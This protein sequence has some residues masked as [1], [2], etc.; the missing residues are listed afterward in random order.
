MKTKPAQFRPVKFKKI[1]NCFKVAFLRLSPLHQ[2]RNPIMFVVYVGAIFT[3]IDFLVNLGQDHMVFYASIPLVIWLT[4]YCANFAEAYAEERGKAQA[5]S[6]KR[7]R[8]DIQAKKILA[9]NAPNHF[10]IIPANHLVTGDLVVVEEGDFIP[11]DGQVVQGIATVDES[12]ITGE[13]AP[14]IRESGGDRDAVTGGTRLLSDTLI[15]RITA[16]PGES[17]LD[18]MIEMVEGASRQKTPNEVALGLL[19]SA[20]NLLF[21]VACATLYPYSSFAVE[22]EGYGEPLNLSILVALFVCIATTTISGLLSAIG[23]AGMNRLMNANVIASSGRAVEAAGDVNI[24]LLDKTGTITLGN[25]KAVAFIPAKAVSLRQLISAALLASLADNTPEGRSITD[26]A[27]TRHGFSKPEMPENSTFVPFSADTRVSGL[28]LPDRAYLK[29]AGDAINE[30]IK[31]EGGFIPEDLVEEMES[32]SIQ[33]GTPL[34]VAQDSQVLGLIHLKDVVKSGI[35]A[36]LAALRRM[37]IRSIMITGDNPLTA[38]AIAAEAGVD[39]FI[40]QATPETKL[41]YIRKMQDQG[42]LIAMV[43]DG[44]N[45]APALAQ[46]DVAV[47]MNTGTQAAKEASNMIDLESNPT[48]L[49]EIVEIGKQL[50]MTRGSL[51]TFSLANDIAKYF[52]ILPAVFVGT[53]PGMAKL[54]IMHLSNPHHAILSSLIFNV[55]I[56]STL[57]PLALRGVSYR[58]VGADSLLRRNLFFYGLGGVI[59]PFIGIKLIDLLLSLITGGTI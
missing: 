49:I 9:M 28:Q 34:V 40:A 50:L 53:Y 56:I 44:T 38:G 37:G 57:I 52:A 11:A 26:L 15:I 46:A 45:D 58:P 48:K 2:L 18:K 16:Q 13:S 51:T 42:E 39:D 6:M 4:V 32:I 23:I 30:H 47:A 41:D 36:R 8:R 33:G 19:L 14:V 22:R 20:L 59:A 54:D 3:S 31:Q 35:K 24:L 21:L 12:A 5:V 27:L 1:A 10:S 25:R 7:A 29:G 55:I 17:Y 43:G